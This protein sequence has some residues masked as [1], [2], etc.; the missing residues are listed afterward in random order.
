[1][2]SSVLGLKEFA[3]LPDEPINTVLLQEE[4]T[5]GQRVEAFN[6]EDWWMVNG[7]Y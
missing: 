2:G 6:V 1:M 3:L 5:K 7:Y 4:I